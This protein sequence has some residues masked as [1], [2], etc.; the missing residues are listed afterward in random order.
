MT[1]EMV[2]IVAAIVVM[3]VL[4]TLREHIWVSIL[5]RRD[6]YRF[7]QWLEEFGIV[8]RRNVT[9]ARDALDRGDI[10]GVHAA[11]DRIAGRAER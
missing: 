5:R 3:I 9:E 11:L 2:E 8:A 6:G 7:S 4:L 10:A 1:R